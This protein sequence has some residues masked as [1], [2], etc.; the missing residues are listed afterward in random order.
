MNESDT[1][2]NGAGLSTAL[3][4]LLQTSGSLAGMLSSEDGFPLATRTK[5]PL[6]RD[7]FAAAGAIIGQLA[8][9]FVAAAESEAPDLVVLESSKYKF[10]VQSVSLGYLMLIAEP[11][12]ETEPIVSVLQMTSKQ[13]ACMASDTPGAT[14]TDIMPC[15][16][17]DSPTDRSA[18]EPGEVRQ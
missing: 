15:N 11:T 13:I 6:D 7:C 16:H 3:D 1:A 5:V 9:R 18:R 4:T 10:V 8:R 14:D 17:I 12:A 2:T